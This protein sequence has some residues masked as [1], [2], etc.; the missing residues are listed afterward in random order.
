MY[1]RLACLMACYFLYLPFGSAGAAECPLDLGRPLAIPAKPTKPGRKPDTVKHAYSL[2]D[3]SIVFLGS[4]TVDADGA[5]KAYAPDDRGLDSTVNSVKPGVGIASTAKNCAAGAPA[6]LQG[7]HDPA[8]GYYVSTTSLTDPAVKDCHRQAR[9]VDATKIP[10]IALPPVIGIIVDHTGRLAMVGRRA[11]SAPAA[12][13]QADQASGYGAGE[14]SVELAR[15]LGLNA[16]PRSGG[17]DGRNYIYVVFPERHGFPGNA[18]DVEAAAL[19]AFQLWGGMEKYE[20]C[21]IA[22]LAAPR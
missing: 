8:P 9:Y 11:G 17:D 12:A 20:A 10:F 4:M 15:R 7:P 14:G 21:R 16:N 6:V 5:P 19:A 1:R 3:G 2:P 22:V 13:M 18:K